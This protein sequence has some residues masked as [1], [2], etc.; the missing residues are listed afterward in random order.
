MRGVVEHAIRLEESRVERDIEGRVVRQ[1][2]GEDLAAPT[3]WVDALLFWY[4]GA[5]RV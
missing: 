4:R 3:V 1:K 2:G 5:A